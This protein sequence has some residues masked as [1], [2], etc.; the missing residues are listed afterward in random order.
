M[1]R[2]EQLVFLAAVLVGAYGG[3][4]GVTALA[5]AAVAYY[6]VRCARMDT[7]RALDVRDGE[8]RN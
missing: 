2:R 8:T 6:V 3:D 5:C 4:R 1:L 7:R